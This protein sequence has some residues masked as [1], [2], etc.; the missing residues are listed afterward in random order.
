MREREGEPEG[1]GSVRSLS[2]TVER[3]RKRA[4]K[5]LLRSRDIKLG[6]PLHVV[7]WRIK[8]YVSVYFPAECMPMCHEEKWSD[9]L[10][11]PCVNVAV[12]GGARQL[13]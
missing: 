9:S 6:Q 12:T 4:R 5:S 2:A 11:G 13:F 1:T 8:V 10:V 7:K 3:A